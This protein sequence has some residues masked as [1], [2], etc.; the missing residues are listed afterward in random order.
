MRIIY[1]NPSRDTMR[2]AL[3]QRYYLMQ[4][5]YLPLPYKNQQKI[6]SLL[7]IPFCGPLYEILPNVSDLGR[8]NKGGVG[9]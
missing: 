5:S 9:Y 2:F 7:C 1:T 8:Q 3:F 6:S 4:I